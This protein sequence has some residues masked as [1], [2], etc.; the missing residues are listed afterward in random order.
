PITGDRQLMLIS[1]EQEIEMGATAYQEF[2]KDA[3]VSTDAAANA[4]VE[5]IGK[6]I[7]A[8]ADVEIAKAGLP[9]FQWEFKVVQDDETVNAFCLPGGKVVV[10]TGILK[11]SADDAEVA[12][13]MG[14]EIAHAIAR[15]GAERV[16]YG[17][18][19]Q[20]GLEAVNVGLSKSDPTTVAAVQGA[21]GIASDLAVMKP[22]SRTQETQADTLGLQL[23]ARAGYDPR[24]AVRFWK[25]MEE[26]GGSQPPEFLSTHPSHAHRVENIESLLPSVIPLYEESR[27]G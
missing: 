12:T 4:R 13:V 3:P 25:R 16:S 6:R 24:A 8:V 27:K 18:V 22:F 15:H 1:T 7:A 19:S 5:A 21:F 17:I 9:A 20:V 23:M 2:L 26:L 10:Y 14:H 11:L